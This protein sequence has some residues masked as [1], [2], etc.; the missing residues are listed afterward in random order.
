MYNE[1]NAEEKKAGMLTTKRRGCIT[2]KVGIF[3][4]ICA[5]LYPQMHIF[6][7]MIISK[8]ETSFGIVV[9]ILVDIVMMKVMNQKKLV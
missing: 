1:C 3:A 2:S 6:C 5:G 8:T 9:I 7:V 4:L